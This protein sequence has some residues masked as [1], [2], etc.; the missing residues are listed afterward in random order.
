VGG[1]AHQEQL[2][3]GMQMVAVVGVSAVLRLRELDDELRKT[4]PSL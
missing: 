4:K 3:T 2:T 1:G